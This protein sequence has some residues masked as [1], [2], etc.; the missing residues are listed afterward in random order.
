MLKLR[1]LGF[2]YR[3]REHGFY[4][5]QAGRQYPMEGLSA[6]LVGKSTLNNFLPGVL[7]SEAAYV[8]I[9]PFISAA[10]VI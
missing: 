7:G 6:S 9:L 4:R 5:V 10:V 1:A 8:P 3:H 2:V